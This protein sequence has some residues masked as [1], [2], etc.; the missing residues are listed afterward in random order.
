MLFCYEYVAVIVCLM[1]V[2]RRLFLCSL[3]WSCYAILVLS[4]FVGSFHVFLWFAFVCFCKG[5]VFAY[6]VYVLCYV[7][8]VFV[9]GVFACLSYCRGLCLVLVVCW[10][11]VSVLC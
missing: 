7:L 8:L 10:Y 5:R 2:S 4:L 3:V 9:S 1:F 11:P 6:R